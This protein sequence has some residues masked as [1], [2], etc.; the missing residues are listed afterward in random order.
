MRTALLAGATGL[1]GGHCLNLLLEDDAYQKVTVLVRRPLSRVH[2][3]LE[4]HIVDFDN[5]SASAAV[6]QADDVFCC[7]GTTIKKAGSKEAFRRVDL[8][9]PEALAAIAAGNGS[10]QFLVI[11]A[12]ESN[13]G[14]PLFY[15]RVKGE[16]EQAVSRHAFKGL[17]IFRPSL[18]I[19]ERDESRL[20]EGLGIKLFTAFPFLLCGPLKR[21]RPIEAAVVA[22]AMIVVAK[23]APGGKRIF[24]SDQLQAIHDTGRLV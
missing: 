9:Y 12:P 11:S 20:A 16:M 15:G 13:P 24:A 10:G 6:I 17:Y 21:L 19:G 2:H 18:L 8:E 7:L 5:L 3:K 23:A 4:E 22:S 1:T 14:S